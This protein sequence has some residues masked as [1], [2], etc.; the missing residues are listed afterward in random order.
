M[1][2][3]V[4]TWVAERWWLTTDVCGAV[5][6]PVPCAA[7]DEVK[8]KAA[9]VHMGLAL[10]DV[11]CLPMAVA[12]LATGWRARSL[13]ADLRDARA[14]LNAAGGTFPWAPVRAAFMP[15]RAVAT[16]FLLLLRDLPYLALVAVTCVLVPWR[17]RRLI[18]QLRATDAFADRVAAAVRTLV[19]V[20]DV[21]AA[22]V[23]VAL[24]GTWR[25]PA[26]VAYA[27]AHLWA[28]RHPDGEVEVTYRMPL[29]QYVS[30]QVV[31]L[32]LDLPF[33]ALS[34]LLLWRA[35]SV[36][37]AVFPA[38]IVGDGPL[39]LHG[40]Q[41]VAEC[42]RERTRTGQGTLDRHGIRLRLRG[43]VP[44]AVANLKF[45]QLYLSITGDEFWRAAEA[46][47]PAAV[48]RLAR[49]TMH[50]L[51]LCPSIAAATDFTNLGGAGGD[52]AVDATL[53]F[54]TGARGGAKVSHATLR[55]LLA[56]LTRTARGD[57]VLELR[58][59]F[60]AGGRLT[61]R[62]Q[63]H[64]CTIRAS[65]RSLLN[66]IDDGNDVHYHVVAAPPRQGVTNIGAADAA[67][68]AGAGA[69][70]GAGAGAGAGATTLSAWGV[71][72]LILRKAAMVVA[73]VACGALAAAT[74]VLPWRGWILLQQLAAG[75]SGFH[76][77]VLGNL[78][79][80][81]LPNLLLEPLAVL[82]CCATPWRGV[83]LVRALFTRDDQAEERAVRTRRLLRVV[84]GGIT[85]IIILS[86]AGFV[87]AT[88]VR[89]PALVA[90]LVRVARGGAPPL[91]DPI[92]QWV[93][94]LLQRLQGRAPRPVDAAD[95]LRAGRRRYRALVPW[96]ASGERDPVRPEE[97]RH[98]RMKQ[99]LG[100]VVI[101]QAGM[102]VLDALQALEVRTVNCVCIVCL[103]LC[104]CLCAC[105]RACVRCV[106]YV[107]LPPS[108][109]PSTWHRYRHHHA[110]V[111][112]GRLRR[113]DAG[114][115]PPRREASLLCPPLLLA[116]GCTTTTRQR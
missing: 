51:G 32:A 72:L 12:T 74:F 89:A 42:P 97:Y 90:G 103:C 63:G 116:P 26:M 25:A 84:G 115:R 80:A 82:T 9:L 64:L 57:T 15:H 69:D 35:P 21:P 14:V 99:R 16:Q 96:D 93:S 67:D 112:T 30:Q 83:K 58:V 73:D 20:L 110:H 62:T 33:A 60:T 38:T 77:A 76:L 18:A 94:R 70:A 91:R 55:K 2:V 111:P 45:R 71:R 102:L 37:R 17:A 28:P 8:R 6:V 10:A 7:S 49:A 107:R 48:I 104:L 1:C 61:G 47:A 108:S 56:A 68:G 81:L 66:C 34:P 40:A 13:L 95:R 50:P 19:Q 23:F 54:G 27:R 105:V 43:T 114:S 31:Q 24:C 44:A 109:L 106:V 85:D 101:H 87:V 41:C 59:D 11:V 98:V 88:G 46:A 5:P 36:F 79:R 100:M 22:V 86:L 29:Y 75:S 39:L 4:C 65:A 52:R 92:V 113:V 78:K 3:L 53:E